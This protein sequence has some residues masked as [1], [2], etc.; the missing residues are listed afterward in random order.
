MHRMQK[1]CLLLFILLT[2]SSVHLIEDVNAGWLDNIKDVF[3]LPQKVNSLQEQYEIAKEQMN[4]ARQ[5]TL[6]AME[7]MEKNRQVL[8]H[9]LRQTEKSLK[10]TIST[11]ESYKESQQ[12]LTDENRK[13]QELKSELQQRVESLR[14]SEQKRSQRYRQIMSVILTAAGLILLYFII[15]RVMR[16]VLRSR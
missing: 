13:L 12:K 15:A 2:A 16:M 10:D 7:E 9:S 11:L 14:A 3:T 4:F 6:K 8:E 5:E 1:I